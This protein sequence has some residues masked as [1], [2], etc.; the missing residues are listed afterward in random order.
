METKISIDE[1][2][3]KIFDSSRIK[4]NF[5]ELLNTIAKQAQEY[6]GCDSCSIWLYNA[7]RDRLI[8]RGTSGNYRRI[9]EMHSYERGKGLH[10]KIFVNK[11][12]VLAQ[13]ARKEEGWK[14]K[15]I[16]EIYPERKQTGGPFLGVPIIFENNN[17]GTLT[18][19]TNSKDFLFTKKDLKFANLIAY[20]IAVALDD[21]INDFEKQELSILR[22]ERLVFLSEFGKELLN[23]KS[24]EEIYKRTT[25]TTRKKLNCRTSSIFLFTKE[26]KLERKHMDGFKKNI[27]LIDTYERGQSLVGKTAGKS[28]RFGKACICN[29]IENEPLIQ[30]DPIA[31]EYIKNYENTLKLE[32]GINEKVKHEITIPLNNIHR[33]FGIIRIINKLNPT[34][35]RLSDVG[36]TE[37]DKEW[38]TLIASLVST[39]VSNIKKQIKSNIINEINTLL[40][41]EDEKTVFNSIA[42]L[43]TKQISSYSGCIIRKL[44][45][46]SKNL[47]IIGSSGVA[48]DKKLLKLQI[49][50]GLVGNTFLSNQYVIIKNLKNDPRGFVHL[51]WAKS[52]N[53]ISA[54]I[55]PLKNVQKTINFGTISLY[56]KFEY[57]FD[58]DN[59]EFLENFANQIANIIQI[60]QEKR[61]LKLINIISEQINR[62]NSIENIFKI[63]IRQ[64]PKITGFDGC[65][66]VKNEVDCGIIVDST[67]KKQC[68]E[69]IPFTSEIAKE[70][71]K[72]PKIR[73]F[74][75]VQKEKKFF[76][77][78]KLFSS[79][80]SMVIVPIT[81]NKKVYGSINIVKFIKKLENKKASKEKTKERF[82]FESSRNLYLTLANQIAIAIEKNQL[83]E[84]IQLEHNRKDII[85]NILHDISSDEDIENNIKTILNKTAYGLKANIGYFA[86]FGK[87]SKLLVPNYCYGDITKGNFHNI[88]I[89]V[90]GI[91]GWVYNKKEAYLWPSGNKLD[92][93][94]IQYKDIKN[95]ISNEIIAP[96]LYSDEVIGLLSVGSIY[97]DTFNKYDKLF[98]ET[99]AN[100]TAIIIQNKMFHKAA[101][102]LAEVRFDEMKTKKICQTLAEKSSEIMNTPVTCVW[103]ICDQDRKKILKMEGW[104]GVDIENPSEYDMPENSGGISWKTIYNGREY[105]ID[106]DLKNPTSGF[107]HPEFAKKYGLISMISVPFG[108]GD[109]ISGVIN[110]YAKRPYRFFDREVA[111]LKNLATSGAI[112]IKNSRLVEESKIRNAKILETA[113]IANPGTVAIGFSHDVKHRIHNINALMSSLI[114]LIPQRTRESDVGKPVIDSLTNDMDYL[115]KL[116]QSLVSYARSKELV[117]GQ[118]KIKDILDYVMYISQLRLTSTNVTTKISYDNRDIKDLKIDCDRSQIEQVFINLFNNSIY[119]I[120]KK[121]QKYGRISIFIRVLDE[122]YIE[123]QFRDD[124]IGIPEE[125]KKL[126][127]E[128][129]F[130][131][132]GS[133]G[134]GFGLFICKRIIEDNHSGRISVESKFNE[135]TTIFIKLLIIHSRGNKK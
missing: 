35:Q 28:N 128:P 64:I 115:R 101:E 38:L 20:E 54:I 32:Y 121:R 43:I 89:G 4:D 79:V 62:E 16:D 27:P 114:Y 127:F 13:E 21:I 17:I 113:Q 104:H 47:I 48:A 76:D 95:E 83:L 34:T 40:A 107:K 74:E 58:E 108:D 125:N 68:G 51:E 10:W 102:K 19:S 46:K 112:A 126:I 109:D 6:L 9:I 39:A 87:H 61:E 50:E 59:I 134:S 57:T 55:L 75:N 3:R 131:T 69:K 56:T 60:I 41:I 22:K 92:N 2:I 116:F 106:K 98:L 49:G 24:L 118:N 37:L 86:L 123:I 135:Y 85:N 65:S 33:T 81:T 117:F 23:C 63:A 71:F 100:E 26:G 111:L 72:D 90:K 53:L 7:D 45:E 124:G 119:A 67:D 73:F 1:S 18:F 77:I 78:K 25:F 5:T 8:I 11:K 130:T 94:Y 80:S 120:S 44:D 82:L 66:I 132:K 14:G 110:T 96:L 52:N 122:K 88:E 15:Y 91:A 133:E 12:P 97:K 129:L 93:L 84:T 42:R 70:I 99:I 30:N 36:F 31:K 103:R 105:I 29:N